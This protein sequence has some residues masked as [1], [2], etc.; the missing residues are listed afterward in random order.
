MWR[1]WKKSKYHLRLLKGLLE[2][3]L[4]FL[5]S[6]LTNH[7]CTKQHRWS[8]PLGSHQRGHHEALDVIQK[9]SETCLSLFVPSIVLHRVIFKGLSSLQKKSFTKDAFKNCFITV[10]CF[11]NALFSEYSHHKLCAVLKLYFYMKQ[12]LLS[13]DTRRNG[14][15]LNDSYLSITNSNRYQPLCL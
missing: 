3:I 5:F 6:W 15:L 12:C 1:S 13:L 9:Q 2:A 10:D 7:H 11:M 8:V 4:Y 14:T